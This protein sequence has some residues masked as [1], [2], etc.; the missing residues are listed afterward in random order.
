MSTMEG[1]SHIVAENV[2]DHCAITASRTIRPPLRDRERIYV[3][4]IRQPI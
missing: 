1:R 4:N 2:Q 3:T